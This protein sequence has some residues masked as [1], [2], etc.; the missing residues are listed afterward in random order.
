MELASVHSLVPA[1]IQ[2]LL[3]ADLQEFY[4]SADGDKK[5][6]WIATSL[7]LIAAVVDLHHRALAEQNLTAKT[8]IHG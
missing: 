6:S 4:A 5:I 8:Q 3:D 7:L 1:P 2:P